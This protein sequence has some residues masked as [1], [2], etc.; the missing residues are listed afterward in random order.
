MRQPRKSRSPEAAARRR[1]AEAALRHE[2]FVLDA[3]LR[4]RLR[5][6]AAARTFRDLAAALISSLDLLQLGVM[7]FYPSVDPE[8]PGCSFFQ[9]ITT[10]HISGHYF[11]P[12]GGRPEIRIDLYCCKS[13]RWKMVVEIVHLHL[14]LE[15][16]RGT[17]VERGIDSDSRCA[18]HLAGLGPRVIERRALEPAAGSR[19]PAEPKNADRRVSRAE[20]QA[21]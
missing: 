18:V 3:Y 12:E 14:G 13:V 10:S 8:L 2:I 7:R 21:L 6:E 4:H 17:Y 20:L 15:A 19:G 5:P 11:E 16:W 1:P 9:P